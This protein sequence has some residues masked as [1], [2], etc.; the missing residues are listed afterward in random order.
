MWSPGDQT[1][2]LVLVLFLFLQ[3]FTFF[4]F[5]ALKSKNFSIFLLKRKHEKIENFEESK[6]SFA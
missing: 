1:H 5:R 3:L 2:D 4:F 6:W